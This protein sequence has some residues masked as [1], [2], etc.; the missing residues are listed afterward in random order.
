MKGKLITREALRTLHKS[1]Y[2]LFTSKVTEALY[3]LP[4]KKMFLK[5][6]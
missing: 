2:I 5:L 6:E 1:L 3:V 4:N